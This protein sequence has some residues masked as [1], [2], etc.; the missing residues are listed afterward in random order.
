V[1]GLRI[2]RKVIRFIVLY[3]LRRDLLEFSSSPPTYLGEDDWFP[4]LFPSGNPPFSLY[5]FLKFFLVFLFDSTK[6]YNVIFFHS[7]L[8]KKG[9]WWR[10]CAFKKATSHRPSRNRQS[11]SIFSDDVQQQQDNKDCGGSAVKSD[12]LLSG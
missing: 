10:D 11:N 9:Q 4:L 3:P 1:N 2:L 5:P 6:T 7:S 8:S 12:S